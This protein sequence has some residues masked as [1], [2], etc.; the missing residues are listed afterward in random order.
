M[1][2]VGVTT[3]D[4][5]ANLAPVSY[6]VRSYSHSTV[7]TIS[8]T[9]V[10]T[11]NAPPLVSIWKPPPECRGRWMLFDNGDETTTLGSTTFIQTQIAANE[12]TTR[13]VPTESVTDATQSLTAPPQDAIIV[14]KRQE[15]QDASA[16]IRTTR[17]QYTV[18]SIDSN[19]LFKSCQ[20][21]QDQPLYSPGVCPDGQQVVEVTEIHANK[22][23]GGIQT[24]WQASCCSSGMTFGS[25]V[26]RFCQ[27]TI[28]SPLD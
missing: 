4:S 14:I 18:W 17:F 20:P 12:T 22:T 8:R 24:S 15:Q 28:S 2:I 23:E 27:S 25:D 19:P 26:S 21:Y 6:D 16:A 3:V 13:L 10:V 7:V 11:E 1:T 5:T 9:A